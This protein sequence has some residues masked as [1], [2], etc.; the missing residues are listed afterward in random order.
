MEKKAKKRVLISSVEDLRP[1]LR[2]KAQRAAYLIGVLALSLVLLGFLIFDVYPRDK[3]LFF[4]CGNWLLMIS[5]PLAAYGM[6]YLFGLNVALWNMGFAFAQ[7]YVVDENG[8]HLPNFSNSEASGYRGYS[9]GSSVSINPSSG[10]PMSGSS[11][12][13]TH[14]NPYGSRSW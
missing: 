12:V 6:G 13:D 1:S 4:L 11:R 8:M 9:I 10:L 5:T 7:E 14:G 2:K 3:D